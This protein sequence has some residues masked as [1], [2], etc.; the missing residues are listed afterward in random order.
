MGEKKEVKNANTNTNAAVAAASSSVEVVEQSQ[1][2]AAELSQ[3]DQKQPEI[4]QQLIE[5]VVKEQRK[6]L[7]SANGQQNNVD[8][9]SRKFAE[10]ARAAR[11]RY[12]AENV[13]GSRESVSA[14]GS[15]SGSGSGS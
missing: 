6:E 11:E 13:D 3:V 8:E 1:S 5:E 2:Q 9:D 12:N 10:A 15:G 4:T 7:Y 14:A